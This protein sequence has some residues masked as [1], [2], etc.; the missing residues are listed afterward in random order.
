MGDLAEILES[1]IV[2][3]EHLSEDTSL[4]QVEIA[5]WCKEIANALREALE[6]VSYD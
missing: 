5:G 6:N 1:C 4:D 2:K 3:L